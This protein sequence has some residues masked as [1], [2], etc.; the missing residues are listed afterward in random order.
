M[1]AFARAFIA[2]CLCMVVAFAPAQADANDGETISYRVKRGD[3]LFSLADRYFVGRHVVSQVARQNNIRNSNL[4]AT[5]RLIRIP[6]SLLKY[7]D[8]ELKVRSFS[9][10]SR[11]S[12]KAPVIG[13]S[14][15]EGDRVVTG[16]NGF[17]RFQGD[18]GAVVSIPSNT[19]AQLVRARQY[20]LG[21]TLD[22][23][24]RISK[25]RGEVVAP[26]LRGQER[27]RV[28]TP[29]AVTAVRG[30]QFRVAHDDDARTSIAEVTEGAVA[31]DAGGQ[32]GLAESGFGVPLTEA[33]V[34]DPEALLPEPA[35]TDP[36][37]VQ[38]RE[39]VSFEIV[40][41]SGA[42]QYRTQIANDAGFTEIIEENVDA[43]T[44]AEFSS[45]PNGTFFVRTRGV[46]PTGV[47]GFSSEAY[48]FKRKRLGVS[49]EASPSVLADG[50]K[51][52]WLGE[53]EGD[54]SYAF[55]LWNEQAPGHP[56][57]DEVGVQ[58]GGLIVTGLEPG[59]YVWRVA[60]IQ[61]DADG[62]L[63]VW[64]PEQKLTVSN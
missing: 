53:G 55:Q 1:T 26:K 42:S 44:E 50:F 15:K 6:R 63:K 45:L 24:F 2:A 28:R 30:T 58:D 49:A 52:A 47:E 16:A 27:F 3:T 35:I 22:V 21:D 20:I 46:S 61:V 19:S 64:S 33:G 8:V 34:G 9:G 37:S 7:R 14:L 59:K 56:I 60:A 43:G 23:D 5:G 36:G 54:S 41:L 11:V 17:I 48:S 62:L 25:G 10:P 31:V 40:P 39:N 18:R 29:M 13:A 51:F 12:D 32:S 38:T 4:I 57:V